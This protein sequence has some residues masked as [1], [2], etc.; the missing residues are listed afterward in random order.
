MHI[1]FDHGE[2]RHRLDRALDI[3]LRCKCNLGDADAIFH[4]DVKIN[5]G[6]LLAYLDLDALGEI[7][8]SKDLCNAAGN[9]AAHSR[10]ALDFRRGKPCDDADDLIRNT[11]HAKP[12][13]LLHCVLL[14]IHVHILHS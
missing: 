4:N 6:F 13:L 2:P 11:D 1:D 10:N 5:S 14:V 3:L 7:L 8:A 9:A 12:G